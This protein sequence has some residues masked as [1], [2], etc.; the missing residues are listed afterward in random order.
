M[1][2]L[3]TVR[4]TA[5]NGPQH[6]STARQSRLF[7]FVLAVAFPA[8]AWRAVSISASVNPCKRASASKAIL[9]SGLIRQLIVS[10]FAIFQIVVQQT[11]APGGRNKRSPARECWVSVVNK[12]RVPSGTAHRSDRRAQGASVVRVPSCRTRLF[13]TAYPGLTSWATIVPPFG[14]PGAHP[15]F[16]RLSGSVAIRIHFHHR[17]DERAQCALRFLSRPDAHYFFG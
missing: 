4:G 13:D 5:G 9:I 16:F 10:V 12:T 1:D 8:T 3:R 2:L 7:G 11:S 15:S 6:F 14:L 17:A